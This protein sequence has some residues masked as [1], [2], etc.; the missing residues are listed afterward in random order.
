MHQKRLHGLCLW[1][2]QGREKQ[3]WRTNS[4]FWS[5]LY[6]ISFFP[7]LFFCHFSLQFL[8]MHSCI[9]ALILEVQTAAVMGV[10]GMFEYLH[11]QFPSPPS[12]HT[13]QKY[14]NADLCLLH[15]KLCTGVSKCI[16]TKRA[17]SAPMFDQGFRSWN[18]CKRDEVN[19]PTGRSL[20]WTYK[21]SRDMTGASPH[22][23]GSL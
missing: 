23:E 3:G 15:A 16:W 21:G 18:C 11:G 2:L 19:A 6:L 12:P 4:A 8:K 7:T 10:G 20:H 14:R 17:W 9:Q 1:K 5:F 22:R 13:T